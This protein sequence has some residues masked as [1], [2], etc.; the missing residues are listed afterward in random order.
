MRSITFLLFFISIAAFPQKAIKTSFVKTIEI[1]AEAIISV[2]KF[3]GSEVIKYVDNKTLFKKIKNSVLYNYSNVQLG[4]ITSVDAFSPLK[5]KLFF[6]NFNTV[7]VLDNRLA[8]TDKI[9][10]NAIKPY[11][12]VSHVSTGFGNKLW[13][14]NQDLQQLEL[15]NYKANK[16]SAKSLPIQSNIIDLKSSYNSCWLLTENYLYK[17]D[18]YGSLIYKIKNKNYTAIALDYNDNILLKSAN[19]LLYLTD[20]DQNITP[21][22]IPKLLIKQ[23]LVT[24]GSLYIYDNEF[25]HEYQLIKD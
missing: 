25:L 13:V 10:F 15:Y 2:E 5:I 21:I 16:V 12:N 8:E 1:K 22:E 18:T 17:Y 9:D 19:R 7:I 23:F 20:R 4:E 6:K 3:N 11:K 14:F 24:R